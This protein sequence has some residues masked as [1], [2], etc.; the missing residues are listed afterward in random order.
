MTTQYE[1]WTWKIGILHGI[2]ECCWQESSG[3]IRK[4]SRLFMDQNGQIGLI[5]GLIGGTLIGFEQIE[6]SGMIV[7]SQPAPELHG[8]N[9][10]SLWSAIR[11]VNGAG[12]RLKLS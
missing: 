8:K 11:P 6:A 5:K 10:D 7:F 12:P 1:T 3:R 4:I 9:C 2:G